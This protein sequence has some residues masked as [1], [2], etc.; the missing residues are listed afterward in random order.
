LQP[1]RNHHKFPE[2]PLYRKY[3]ARYAGRPFISDAVGGISRGPLS[4]GQGHFQ[5]GT[6]MKDFTN[7]SPGASATGSYAVNIDSAEDHVATGH[8][9]GSA[10]NPVAGSFAAAS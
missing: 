8:A 6:E 9:R 5:K 4:R 10:D 7:F 3:K 1:H 2:L